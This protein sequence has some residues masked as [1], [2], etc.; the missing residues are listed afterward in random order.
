MFAKVSSPAQIKADFNFVFED[1]TTAIEVVLYLGKKIYGIGADYVAMNVA[2]LMRFMPGNIS[3]TGN[4]F[5]TSGQ[6]NFYHTD[7][8]NDFEAD[9]WDERV[10]STDIG[11]KNKGR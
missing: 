2:G 7:E 11:A 5:G 9:D 6:K 1:N 4:L 3:F 10:G 8:S